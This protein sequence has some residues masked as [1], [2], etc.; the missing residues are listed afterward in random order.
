M[1]NTEAMSFRAMPK[2]PAPARLVSPTMRKLCTAPSE[3]PPVLK[4]AP[5]SPEPVPDTTKSLSMAVPAAFK[6]REPPS[7]MVTLPPFTPIAEVFPSLSTPWLTL[8]VTKLV[9]AATLAVT[10]LTP[11]L[12]TT[13]EPK[14]DGVLMDQSS[15]PSRRSVPARWTVMLPAP[16]VPL[17]PI[18]RPRVPA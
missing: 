4:S 7:V 18:S 15:K 6:S 3:L 2:R 13:P 10:V 17:R 16:V 8:T 11:T 9:V 1:S 12:V 14:T 5:S